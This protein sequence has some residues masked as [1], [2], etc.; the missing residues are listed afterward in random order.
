MCPSCGA[1]LT[2]LKCTRKRR[3]QLLDRDGWQF[4]RRPALSL[5]AFPPQF[6][7]RRIIRVRKRGEGQRRVFLVRH[8]GSVLQRHVPT[9][10][11]RK[12]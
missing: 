12:R 2:Q 11:R 4:V 1:T 3:H 7:S 9:A 10:R 5:L 8:L 6:A